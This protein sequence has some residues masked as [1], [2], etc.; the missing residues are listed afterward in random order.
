MW[1]NSWAMISFIRLLGR[2]AA[3]RW[4]TSSVVA[5]TL[6]TDRSARLDASSVDSITWR[7]PVIASAMGRNDTGRGAGRR[8]IVWDSSVM[9]R[10]ASSFTG[11]AAGPVARTPARVDAP[12]DDSPTLDARAAEPVAGTSDS[13]ICGSDVDAERV[14][15]LFGSVGVG[16]CCAETAG[17]VAST[18]AVR[19]GDVVLVGV[20]RS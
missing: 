8:R 10:S 13:R 3:A 16:A 17:D 19:A 4:I 18:L 12:S 15:P 1:V 6:P 5:A 7:P 14:D 9:K 2:G 11:A 20:G